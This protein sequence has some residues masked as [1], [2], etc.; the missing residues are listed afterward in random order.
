[1]GRFTVFTLAGPFASFGEVAGNERRG[2]ADRPGH[3]MLAGLVAAALGIRRH[4]EETLA[5]LSEACRFAV[6]ADAPGLPLL[7]YHTVQTAKGRRFDASTRRTALLSGKALRALNTTITQRE[8][9]TDVRFT[10]ALALADE[11]LEHETIAEALVRPHF[12]LYL[13]RKA[14]PP[15][16]PLQPRT[17]EAESPAEAFRA[18]DLLTDGCASRFWPG[19]DP[20]APAPALAA[21]RRLFSEALPSG[22]I[23]RRRTRPLARRSW[24]Y[25]L[26]DELVLAGEPPGEAE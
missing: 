8:Y 21:D 1:M 13:G 11:A 5:R 19:R 24:R 16:L 12:P 2:S 4:E 18:Y 9:R 6:R 26:L 14:C 25:A 23:E 17:L 22:R 10:V 20:A 15:A 7:D 3:A